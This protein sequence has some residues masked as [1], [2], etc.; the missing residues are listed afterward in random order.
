M[1]QVPCKIRVNGGRFPDK[2]LGTPRGRGPPVP[3]HFHPSPSYSLPPNQT[4]PPVGP[5]SRPSTGDP[6]CH[7]G[8]KCDRPSC[9][10]D[11][12]SVSGSLRRG[13]SQ[14]VPR[15][16]VRRLLRFPPS[17]YRDRTRTP[18]TPRLR[19]LLVTPTLTSNHFTVK[20][21]LLP[22]VLDLCQRSVPHLTPSPRTPFHS[23]RGRD[24]TPP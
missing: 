22:L 10:L 23:R 11:G 15:S 17:T 8:P 9:R 6:E 2:G 7:S 21:P 12:P 24:P 5:S 4:P 1:T 20:V 19:V 16:P 18:P 3:F 14:C 13:K